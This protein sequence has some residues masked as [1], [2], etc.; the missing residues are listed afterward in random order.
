MT[1]TVKDQVIEINPNIIQRSKRGR[2]F[3]L[4]RILIDYSRPPCYIN[5]Q[6]SHPTY[7]FFKYLDDNSR[8]ALYFNGYNQIECKID[9]KDILNLD[10]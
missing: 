3:K 5:K 8:F 2:D 9:D 4:T 1:L 10:I 7:Y 6:Q